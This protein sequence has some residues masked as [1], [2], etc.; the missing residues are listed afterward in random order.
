MSTIS[1]KPAKPGIV[2]IAAILNFFST[3]TFFGLAAFSALAMVFGAAWGVDEVVRR[4]MTQWAPNPNY[5]YGLAVL[6]GAAFAFFAALGIFFLVIG[7]ALLRGKRYGWY[8]QVAMSTLGLLSLPL[9]LATGALALPIGS[10]LNIV[11][12][13]MFFQP[14]VREYFRV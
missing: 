13:L 3:F 10:V 4:Q 6:F 8:L 1:D 11:I 12:L 5:S 7:A 9:G 14:R 2:I